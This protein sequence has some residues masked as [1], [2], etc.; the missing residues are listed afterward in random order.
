LNFEAEASGVTA[1]D[2]VWALVHEIPETAV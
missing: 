2:V 1:D